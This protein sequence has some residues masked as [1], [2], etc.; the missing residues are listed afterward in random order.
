MAFKRVVILGG[1]P[2]G[3]LCAIEA[4]KYFRKV[5]IVE[6]RSGY[7]RVNV[8][9]LGRQLLNHLT[10]IGVAQNLWP[11]G[12]AGAT[13]L[14]FQRLEEAL[15]GKA[16]A[17]GVLMERGYVVSALTG[18]Q[19]MPNGAYK[20]IKLEFSKWDEEHKKIIKDATPIESTVADLL[21]VASGGRASEDQALDKLDFS[22]TKLKA[23]NYAA[24]GIF[25]PPI[26]D[27]KLAADTNEFRGLFGQVIG[28]KIAFPTPDHN[29]LLIQLSK[30]TKSDFKYLQTNSKALHTLLTTV[31]A[32]FMSDIL[33]KIKEGKKSTAVFEVQIQRARHLRSEKYPAVI[34]G[35][36]A[37]TPHPKAG[38]G[39]ETGFIGVQQVSSLFQALRKAERAGDNSRAWN[40]FNQSYDKHVSKKALEGTE[41][42]LSNIIHLLNQFIEDGKKSN[43]GS[44]TA[45]KDFFERT[46]RT[47][48]DLKTELESQKAKAKKLSGI[49]ENSPTQFKW[50]DAEDLWD[51][52]Y[53]T[54][55]AVKALTAD[56]GLFQGRV[57]ELEKALRK[58][59][60]GS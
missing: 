28:D 20:E 49:L 46:I 15:W 32:G 24:Y 55:K 14:S 42:I 26:W 23:K 53:D 19:Q 48:S 5:F 21:V 34:V 11:T 29:Y 58:R 43:P 16:Q 9:A 57:D 2:I 22:F 56:V 12:A 8:P 52:I 17:D 39:L 7:N 47:A 59:K 27:G 3:L 51:E 36:A 54:Y 38:T 60:T 4:K 45:F 13:S 6:K 44:S 30:C 50:S 33:D 35:D 37:V 31:S 25:T 1:G 40:N 41:V 10:E 18:K